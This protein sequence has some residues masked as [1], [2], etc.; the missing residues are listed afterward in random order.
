MRVFPLILGL[1]ASGAIGQARADA[2]VFSESFD[3]LATMSSAGWV[4]N[5][6]STLPSQPWFQGNP[7]IFPAFAGAAS[8]YAA[9]SFLSSG[10]INGVVSNWMITPA[11]GLS[12]GETLSFYARSPTN[13]FTDGLQV[14]LSPTG[15]SAVG[16]FTISLLSI[17]AAP[18]GWTL[19]SVV[20]PSLGGP[21]SARVAFQYS[22][23]DAMNADYIGIDSLTI[24]PIPEP[25]SA[26]LLGLGLA[27]LAI[28]RRLA[29]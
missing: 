8:S 7:G 20:V 10:A 24:A 9:A 14:R 3:S 12:G 28:R 6:Q 19:Y 27:G 5:N 17:A 13:E 15:S 11:I 1:L 2:P 26:V 23:A 25:M 29:A 4:F 22:V 21:A 18:T 16:D